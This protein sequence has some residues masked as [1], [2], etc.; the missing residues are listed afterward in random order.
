MKKEGVIFI[1]CPTSFNLMSG[2][3]FLPLKEGDSFKGK[4]F[5]I[6]K[7]TF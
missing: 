7:L 2:S 6:R 1:V 5:E 4:S 3:N